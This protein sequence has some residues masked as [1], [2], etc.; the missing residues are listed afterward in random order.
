[1]LNNE[2][3]D[4][5]KAQVDTEILT[6]V[7]HL[8]KLVFG[9]DEYHFSLETVNKFL[10]LTK[11]DIAALI[12]KRM[13]L[14][15][16]V[17]KQWGVNESNLLEIVDT[18]MGAHYNSEAMKAVVNIIKWLGGFDKLNSS[19]TAQDLFSDRGEVS[20]QYTLISGI[21]MNKSNGKYP[22]RYILLLKLDQQRGQVTDFGD[23][24]EK[25]RVQKLLTMFEMNPIY[26]D[27]YANMITDFIE[28]THTW[29]TATDGEFIIDTNR[30][31]SLFN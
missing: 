5:F 26:L 14:G 13:F 22:Y 4:Y 25:H 16:Q 18:S 23:F 2:L 3:Q 20:T 7:N 8:S 19:K 15:F 29:L 27:T 12:S 21:E 28:L 9:Y 1:M 6:I 30:L 11:E 17:F 31:G 10:N 24:V